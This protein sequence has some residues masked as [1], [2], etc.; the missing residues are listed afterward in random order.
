[1][2]YRFAGFSVN[3]DTRQLLAGGGEVHL[4]PKAFE[5]LLTL[6]EHRSRALSKAELQERGGSVRHR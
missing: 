2:T 6:I 1:V 4:S 3:S 5:L